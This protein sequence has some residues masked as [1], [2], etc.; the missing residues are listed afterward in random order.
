MYFWTLRIVAFIFLI[1][2]IAPIFK[3]YFN[4]GNRL[5]IAIC[6][7]ILLFYTNTPV[8][9]S[10]KTFCFSS[11]VLSIAWNTGKWLIYAFIVY[12]FLIT[13]AIIIASLIKP[14]K[15]A[16][17]ITLGNRA[18]SNGP[19]LL[20]KGRIDATKRYLDDN[21]NAVAVLS[22]GKCKRDFIAEADCMFSELKN[23][24]IDENRLLIE[25]KSKSTFE[26]ILFSYRIIREHQEEKNLAIVSDFFHQLRAR[27]IIK[28]LG[29]KTKVGAVNSRT[30][31]LY[32]PT[33]CVREWI[34]LPYELLFRF[35]PHRQ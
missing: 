32:I 22:G 25:D 11:P 16:T 35:R 7:F 6:L 34:A 1:W 15:N 9:E 5:G 2:F 30:S 29:I 28:K 26:N 18:N 8:F 3:K 27:L 4:H 31:F 19:S 14:A 10:V 17:A 33:Y 23:D 13:L 12:A 20:L 21:K 24:G